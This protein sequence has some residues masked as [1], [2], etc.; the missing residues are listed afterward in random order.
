[1]D[2]VHSVCGILSGMNDTDFTWVDHTELPSDRAA[3]K[4]WISRDGERVWLSLPP[5]QDF[6]F[7]PNLSKYEPPYTIRVRQGE[8]ML[9]VKVTRPRPHV[10]A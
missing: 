1:M 3:D 6:L 8:K 9:Y 7:D 2:K 5:T 10:P 4:W